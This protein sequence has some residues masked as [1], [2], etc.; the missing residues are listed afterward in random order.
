MDHHIS[1][2]F[3]AAKRFE[4]A[5]SQGSFGAYRRDLGD[6]GVSREVQ[7]SSILEIEC[8]TGWGIRGYRGHAKSCET[9]I[10][11][12]GPMNA[13]AN[14]SHSAHSCRRVRG[15]AIAVRIVSMEMC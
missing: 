1:S 12:S 11:K 2:H 6:E 7:P 5:R 8:D 4:I 13:M 14:Q 10:A 15:N 9:H 3:T